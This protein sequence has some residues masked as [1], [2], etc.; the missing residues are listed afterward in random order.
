MLKGMRTTLTIDDDLATALQK[1]GKTRKQS[2]KVIVN[3]ALRRG[4][5]ELKSRPRK[6]KAYKIRPM[7]LGQCHLE[8]LDCTSD[9]L[10]FAEG[11]FRK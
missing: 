7:D 11:D 3:D 6:G 1:L 9:A 10:D 4:L 8:N 2:F 5:G